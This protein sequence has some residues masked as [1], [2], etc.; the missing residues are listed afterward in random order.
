M[1][2]DVKGYDGQPECPAGYGLGIP[3]QIVMG[4]TEADNPSGYW[5]RAPADIEVYGT[6]TSLVFTSVN[7]IPTVYEKPRFCV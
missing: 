7:V 2:H 5:P 1:W 4:A 6:I 3:F